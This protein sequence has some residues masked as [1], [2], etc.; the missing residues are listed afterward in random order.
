MKVGSFT[1]ANDKGQ[2]V[3][4]KD[5]RDALGITAN[6]TLNITQAGQGIYIYPVEEFIT[7]SEMESSYI[8]LLKK[9]QGSWGN[10]PDAE[11][12]KQRRELEAKAS[13]SRKNSW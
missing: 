11:I 7:K 8:D 6:V 4:P 13:D 5:I 10:E 1:T 9:T 3:I 2:I 12:D